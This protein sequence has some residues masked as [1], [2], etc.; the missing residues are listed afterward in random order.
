VR[1]AAGLTIVEVA[2]K[3]PCA[4]SKISRIETG[5][6]GASSRDVD[7]LLELYGASAQQKNVVLQLTH[8]ARKEQAEW[9]LFRGVPNV[10]TYIG[11]EIEAA[12]ICAYETA[13]IPG[14]LQTEHY[15]RNIIG[16]TIPNL[17]PKE[18]ERYVELRMSRQSLLTGD[19]P[20]T[21]QVVLEEAALR[22]LVFE[23]QAVH[24]QVVCLIE[25]ACRT[26]VI[27][28]VVPHVTEH[29]SVVGSFRI[30]SFRNET[31]PDVV[32][33][34]YISGE[35]YIRAFADVQQ[36]EHTFRRLQAAALTPTKSIAFL[37]RWAKK[38]S[39]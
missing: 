23:P 26:N 1:K 11:F 15:A 2:E 27:L 20:L 6:V 10:K 30:L 24:E 9:H 4:P 36:Y 16:V 32:Y 37:R 28:Q 25:A 12:T 14:L 21:L 17:R 33:L 13:Y 8:E 5:L 39:N 31:D 7:D 38:F 3:L 18:I 34:E 22:R 29:V 19:N 35:L